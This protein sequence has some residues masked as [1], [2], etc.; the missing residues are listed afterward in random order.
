MI[1]IQRAVNCSIYGRDKKGI[2][3]VLDVM[4]FWEAV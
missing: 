1:A 4:D 3:I 2:N